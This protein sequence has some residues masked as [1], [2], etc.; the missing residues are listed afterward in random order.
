MNIHCP[1]DRS[2]DPENPAAAKR[3]DCEDLN[4]FSG[5]F[6]G[7]E[8]E[9]I[10]LSPGKFD[11]NVVL[12][13][14]DEA[15]IHI[16]KCAHAIEMRMKVDPD[17][18]L[19]CICLGDGHESLVFG[20]R[21]PGSWIFVLPPGG[22]AA[23]PVPEDCTLLTLSIARDAILDSDLLVRNAK[24]WFGRIRTDGAFVRSKR[25]TSRMKEDILLAHLGT[26]GGTGIANQKPG[27]TV[28]QAMIS[29]LMSAFSL[30]WLVNSRFTVDHRTPAADRFFR[31]RRLISEHDFV[32]GDGLNDA[33]SRLGS[34]RSVEQAFASHVR[35][36]PHS[37]ARAVRLH[38]ARRRLQDSRYSSESV[39]NIAAREGFWDCS[40]FALYYRKHFGEPPSE[41]R[42]KTM[43]RRGCPNFSSLARR[44]RR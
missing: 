21:D 2:D 38:N 12:A 39:G 14:M 15:S 35:M 24:T 44:F 4:E 30:E 18:F 31:A 28:C 29:G 16:S 36:G 20:A 11:G 25:L 42:K 34:M 23:M 41:T 22:A 3:V 5:M 40:R 1:V 13:P 6:D 19:F 27:Q 26:E 7:V 10:Q 17:K 37:Y 8:L 43:V 33:L 32:I 9:G